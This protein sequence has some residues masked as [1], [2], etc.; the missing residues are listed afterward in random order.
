MA[1]VYIEF[2]EGGVPIDEKGGCEICL[3]F[4]L[5]VY[6]G[7]IGFKIL[8]YFKDLFP[9]TAHREKKSW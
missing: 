4:R 3:S 8:F 5:A 2:M 1:S 6:D 9:E 7:N